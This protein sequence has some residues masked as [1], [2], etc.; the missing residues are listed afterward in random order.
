MLQ[1]KPVDWLSGYKNKTRIYAVCKRPTLDLGTHTDWKREDGKRYSIQMEI[2]RSWRSNT[3]NQ[4]KQNLFISFY[5]CICS[6]FPG[7][8]LNLSCRHDLMLQLQQCQ[9]L[10]PTVSGQG[11]NQHLWNDLSY[12]SQILNPLCHSGTSKIDFIYLFIFLLINNY[13]TK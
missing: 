5:C 12:C 13:F 11:L 3:H 10:C 2:K 6:I 1:S 8:G 7:Q 4:T 9:I